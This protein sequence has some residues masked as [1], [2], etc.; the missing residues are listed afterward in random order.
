LRWHSLDRLWGRT[1]SG[2]TEEGRDLATA[3]A[4]LRN[5]ESLTPPTKGPILAIPKPKVPARPYNVLLLQAETLNARVFHE[6]DLPYLDEFKKKC[7]R[8]NRHFSVANAT[9]YGIMGL[10]HGNPVTFF[11]GPRQV[12]RPNPYLDHFKEHGYKTR[13]I[14]RSVMN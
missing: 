6:T 3:N 5:L 10:L 13:L 12:H 7:L 8:L 9:H 11:T 2:Y 1:V 14:T 4:A